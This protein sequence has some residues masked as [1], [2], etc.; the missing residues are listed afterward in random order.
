MALTVVAVVGLVL[1]TAVDA[2]TS[3]RSASGGDTEAQETSR[4]GWFL[5]SMGA[6][7]DL[8]SRDSGPEQVLAWTSGGLPDGFASAVGDLTEVEAISVTKGDRVDLTG[9]WDA[10]GT[11]IT[12]LSGG[13]IVPL[14]GFSVDP[15]RFAAFVPDD[16]REVVSDLGDGEALLSESSA[17]LRRADVGATLAFGDERVTVVGVVPDGP[18]GAAEVI[19]DHA[20]GERIGIERARFVLVEHTGDPDATIERIRGLL[21]PDEPARI[22]PLDDLDLVR[23]GG[24]VLPQAHVKERFGEF[25]LRDHGRRGFEQD[26]AWIEENIRTE[27]VPLLGRI[28]CH[29]DYFP[30]IRGALQEL[31]DRGLGHLVSVRDYGGCWTPRFSGARRS[32]S[33]HAWGITADFNISKNPYGAEPDQDPRLVEIM[34]SWGMNWGGRWL[35]PD[36]MHFEH[37]EFP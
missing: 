7:G 30:A 35:V 3:V 13:W 24:G 22:T 14:E 1:T 21:P 9:S 16:V 18:V 5:P 25:S 26:P 23:Q 33:R 31:D 15:A 19:V 36:A 37:V 32:V 17:R 29:K 34:K 20:T 12:E 4:T 28:T 2:D 8:L 27:R 6:L 11:P 10:D